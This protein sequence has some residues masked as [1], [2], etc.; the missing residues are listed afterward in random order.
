MANGLSDVTITAVLNHLLGVAAYTAPIT[1]VLQ[2]YNGDP[3]GAG[4]E[5]TA[6]E[7]T[8]YAEQSI[9]FETEGATMAGRSYNDTPATF[10]AVVAGA[11][12]YDVTHWA[13]VDSLD[14]IIAAGALPTTVSRLLGEPLA[15]AV[16]AIYIELTRTA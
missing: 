6:T 15:F 7:D 1:H 8:A 12:P 9:S 14:V 13:V 3:H 10:L 16:G 2:L 5:I 4:V 11:P